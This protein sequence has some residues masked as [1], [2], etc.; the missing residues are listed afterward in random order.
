V[1]SAK[2]TIEY[3]FNSK[4]SVSPSGYVYDKP[5]FRYGT[6][7]EF[8]AS[9]HLPDYYP[10]W[11]H[12]DMTS[13]QWSTDIIKGEKNRWTGYVFDPYPDITKRTLI[14]GQE[15]SWY[16]DADVDKA[17]EEELALYASTVETLVR[18]L[19]QVTA[20]LKAQPIEQGTGRYFKKTR[21]GTKRT[22][23]DMVN[24]IASKLANPEKPY[25]A[26]VKLGTEE[27]TIIALPFPPMDD[28]VTVAARIERIRVHTREYYCKKRE[29]IKAEIVTRQAQL[30]KEDKRRGRTTQDDEE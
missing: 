28:D 12:I 8:A 24:E 27:H 19:H 14:E 3:E 29:D 9:Y 25:T 7:A 22:Y 30:I 18:E 4:V 11:L 15:R 20:A 2:S 13:L 1:N 16:K 10:P 5:P 17:V 23:A 21:P 26:R 6:S